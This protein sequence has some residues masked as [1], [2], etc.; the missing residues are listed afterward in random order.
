MVSAAVGLSWGCPVFLVSDLQLLSSVS[1]YS[2]M[3]GT[4]QLLC[5]VTCPLIGYIMD[6]KMKECNIESNSGTEKRYTQHCSRG[7]YSY[8]WAHG[9]F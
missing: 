7:S 4:L 1:F 9:Y 3:F 6:W 2:S 5:L 8:L